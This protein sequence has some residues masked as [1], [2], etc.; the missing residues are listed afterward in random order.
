VLG[1]KIYRS[2]LDIEDNVDLACVCV[3][4]RFVPDILRDCLKKG[5][6]AAI[7]LSAGFREFGEAGR[8]LEE[9]VAE[10]ARQGIR[11][12][13]PNCFG[14]YCPAGKITVVPGGGFPKQAGAPRSSRRAVSCPKASPPVLSEKHQVLQ[15]GQLW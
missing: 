4:A 14:T 2:V 1:R 9:D 13:G 12:M 10:I 8:L 6:K 11:V 15:G 5:V 7:V 3:S